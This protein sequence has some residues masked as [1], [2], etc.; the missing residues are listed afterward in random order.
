MHVKYKIIDARI[1]SDWPL[2]KHATDGSAGIDL[3]A[4]LDKPLTLKSGE[5]QL[6]SSGISIY[7]GN[8]SYAAVILP[9]SGLGHK[10]GIVMGNLVGLI[11]ADYQ[12]ELNISVWNRSHDEFTIHPGDRIAQ[13]VFI[14]V[15]QPQLELVDDYNTAT[16]RGDGGFGSTG[17]G[18]D[19]QAI[20]SA[21]PINFNHL[22]DI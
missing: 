17:K 3:T 10:K 8:P 20:N 1:G 18:L 7:I 14:P 9:R 15:V 19:E 6:V 21:K 2:P 4:C 16:S 13:L 11:D 12:G 22:A 5:C